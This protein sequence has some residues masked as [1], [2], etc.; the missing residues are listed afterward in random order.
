M[1]CSSCCCGAGSSRQAQTGQRHGHLD[2]VTEGAKTSLRGMQNPSIWFGGGGRAHGGSIRCVPCSG[3]VP[4]P[5]YLHNFITVQ[6][7]PN[8]RS[9]SLVTL[10]HPSTSSSVRITDLSFQYA[11]LCLW[12]QLTASLYQ[13]RTN[14]SSSDSPSPMSGISPTGSI[15]SHHPPPFHSF[16]QGKKT[17]LQSFP[18]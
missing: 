16:I 6:P 3:Y 7:S 5:S 18:L 8:A 14:L 10:I 11:S 13:P 17:F 12:N 4:E 1:E 2:V 15:D 9:S